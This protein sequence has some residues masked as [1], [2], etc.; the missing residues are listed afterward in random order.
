MNTPT[1]GD[2]GCKLLGELVDSILEDC[3]I[4]SLFPCSLVCRSW[5]PTCR[6]RLFE[7]FEVD[8][9]SLE[10]CIALASI[11]ESQCCTIPGFIRQLRLNL[12]APD[13]RG[14]KS[15]DY[16]LLITK[17]L[18]NKV[19]SL[20]KLAIT[21]LGRSSILSYQ[22]VPPTF[23]PRG[24]AGSKEL[25][26][27]LVS[28]FNHVLELET[29]LYVEDPEVFIKFISSF[30]HLEILKK[31]GK[32]NYE[33]HMPH[34]SKYTLPSPYKFSI[35]EAETEGRCIRRIPATRTTTG[36]SSLEVVQL[37]F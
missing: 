14:R 34:L 1:Q 16:I 8:S 28:S 3:E 21:S 19:D 36:D 5:L 26:S 37:V 13:R 24:S 2:L 6:S 20:R 25:S 33:Y 10:C 15:N 12:Q 29:Q 32:Y 18:K 31:F 23:D 30:S 4:S 27:L 35:S 11:L 9:T 7:T 22:T 17:R